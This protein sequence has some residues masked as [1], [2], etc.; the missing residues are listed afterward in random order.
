VST[1]EYAYDAAGNRL[2][3]RIN[4]V[5]EG[6]TFNNVNELVSQIGGGPLRFRGS[7]NEPISNATVVGTAAVIDSGTN[8]T[9][10]ATVSP[11]SNTVQVAASDYNGNTVA[12]HYSVVLSN[13]TSQTLTYDLNGNLITI[14]N[15]TTVISNVWDAAN[16][17]VK[18]YSNTTYLSEFMYDGY[19]RRARQ[20]EISGTT[21]NSDRLLLWC[22]TEISEE[23]DSTGAT[24]T[25]RF[26][27]QGE[28]IGGTNCF[29]TRDHLSSICEMTDGSGLVRARYNY[30]PWG[31]RTK[32]GGDLDADFGFT[33]HYF[34]GPSGLHLAL[35]RAYSA[36][37][38]RWLSRD[39]IGEPAFELVRMGSV[40]PLAGGPNR[41]LYVKDN[42]SD[43]Y[44]IDGLGGGAACA[45]CTTALVLS[46][47][48]VPIGAIVIGVVVVAGVAYIAYSL[49]TSKP[50]NKCPPCP[51]CPPG[52][53]RLDLV[54]PSAP[55]WPCPGDHLNIW[56][57]ESN[58]EPWPSCVC[59]CNRKQGVICL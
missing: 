42:P 44:D 22:G 47:A 56:W 51:P 5:V 45:A 49:C 46:P 18:I 23:R 48:E 43:N 19:G 53:Q 57:Y 37:L 16:R 55:H 13:G 41:Y 10:Y 38:G 6:A 25:K 28:Q 7:L 54:P 30:D 33:G 14:S 4:S 17:L 35:Y 32:I 40:S 20:I 26:F 15:S 11:G 58:Q 3:E 27:A 34:H 12:H 9:G 59:H 31:R 52:G 8:F 21:T 24:V 36:D 39:P 29:F 2:S 50:N 1:N